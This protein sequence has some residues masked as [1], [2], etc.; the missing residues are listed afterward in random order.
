MCF[1]ERIIPFLDYEHILI[2]MNVTTDWLKRV[3]FLGFL[4]WISQ[5]NVAVDGLPLKHPRFNKQEE[6]YH[7]CYQYNTRIQ[8]RRRQDQCRQE[9]GEENTMEFS[10]SY[11]FKI[12]PI[13]HTFVLFMLVSSSLISPIF[14]SSLEPS[15]E[16]KPS[17]K[18]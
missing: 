11:C 17:N 4:N 16:N 6:K 9:G 15:N 2:A 1:I 8:R 14:C 10:N 13:I 7:Y 3:K 12:S 5:W 18:T